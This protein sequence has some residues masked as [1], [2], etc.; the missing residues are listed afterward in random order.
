MSAATSPRPF[1]ST[2]EA[3]RARCVEFL[4][5][6]ARPCRCPFELREEAGV[7]VCAEC[8]RPYLRR[9]VSR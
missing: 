9:S 7:L 4:S 1:R 8:G 6:H 2:E 3:H 5:V